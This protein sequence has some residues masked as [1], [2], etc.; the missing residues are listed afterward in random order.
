MP[1]PVAGY[2]T[3]I[4]VPEGDTVDVG[5][6]LAVIADA[7]P[8]T[9][10]RRAARRGAAPRRRPPQPAPEPP[11]S[12]R[13]GAGR[14]RAGPLRAERRAGTRPRRPAPAP[15]PAA[16][17]APAP[18]AA[19]ATGCCRRSCAGSIAEHGLD[20]ATITGTGAGGR[21]TRDDVLDRID[22]T[23]AARRGAAP[24]GPG[25]RAGTCRAARRTAPAAARPPPP[26][27]PRPSRPRPHRRARHGRAA[28]QHPQ[29]A[30]ASTWSVSKATSP[31]AFTVDRGRLRER[32]AGAPRRHGRVQGGGGLQPHLPAVHLPG[33]D[34]RHRRVPAHERHR[35]RRRA[36]R[37]QL[38]R[39]SAS[40]STSTSRACWSR[41]STTPTTSGCGPS[42]ARSPTSP[43]GPARKKLS[44]DD[45]TG[46][47]FTIT[48]PGSSGT[49]LTLPII[50][51][52][53][54]AILSTDGV[55]RRPVVVD[56]PDGSEAH[57]HPLGRQPGPELG[58][59]GL[60]RRLRR[61]LPA[62][63]SRRSSR[64]ATGQQSCDARVLRVRWLGRV[65]LPRRARTCSTAL[66]DARRRR[67]PAAARAPARLHAR[68]AG[69]PRP[70][71]R[72]A[73]RVGAELVRADR[74]GDVTY[75]GP[76]P[77]RRLPDP[78]R[79][80]GSAAATAWPTPSPTSA[81]VE[82]L[83]ID[84]L[85]R[86]R[87]A[88][89]RRARRLPGRVGR[90]R[91]RRPRKIAAIGVRLTRGRSMHGFALNVDPDLA[92]FGH[93]VPC[94]IADK[95][96]TSLAAEGVDVI[97]A[98]GR[99]RR[100]RPRRRAVGRRRRGERQTWCGATAPTTC[101]RSAGARAPGRAPVR[102]QPRPARL[103]GRRD[104]GPRD[105]RAQARVAAGAGAAQRP[106]YLALKQT[107][108]D[109]DLVTVCE[110]AG[111]PN[112]FECWADGTATF[113]IN[114]ERCTRACGF[115]L[116]DTRH[117]E[118]ARPRRARRGSPRP[119][120]G[121][122]CAYAV[123]TAVARDDLADGGAARLRRDD[124]GHPAPHARHVASRC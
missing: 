123:V 91:H 112:I 37:A 1:S 23:P 114:G 73:G 118:R 7:P 46:G 111:C 31:H 13:A 72:A 35:R 63:R 119:S 15:A 93:I 2:L 10:P 5:T 122:A 14:A 49:L 78:H 80:P 4:K 34:R 98:R 92:M 107:M 54:V 97:D 94:G 52:P 89:R 56:R 87:P 96:V 51:Q 99:R 9:A 26:P 74:G 16:A 62:S 95:G 100:G 25:R 71:P 103:R 38:R 22:G 105:R 76:G 70:R 29:A 18:A 64:P 109:L 11:P 110:E 86:P 66:F 47:T 44:P 60:R 50:N 27:G 61:R 20:P 101:R 115:C 48:N 108:R 59:P 30:P 116:V 106:T 42:P 45:I 19:T 36:D 124:R 43:A 67:P 85:G 68:R 12:A 58:P 113:M 21:I 32:R 65:P 88:R 24:A 57:R 117:P 69:R 41:S 81:R 53:Q 79:C 40:P 82:Q 3:E 104:R 83:V 55:K 121:W 102:H 28:Q 8:A 17:P 75:H 90:R 120:S 84:A 33:R 39:T 6:V 77:A